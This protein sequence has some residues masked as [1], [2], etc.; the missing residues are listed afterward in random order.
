MRKFLIFPIINVLVIGLCEMGRYYKTSVKY[1]K[2][3]Y[4]YFG[5]FYHVIMFI[6][7]FKLSCNY[8]FNFYVN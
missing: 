2:E 3:W 8:E 5:I 4:F 6:Y 1:N 7:T